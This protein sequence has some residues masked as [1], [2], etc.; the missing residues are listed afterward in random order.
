MKARRCVL[1]AVGM[2]GMEFQVA[3]AAH[4]GQAVEEWNEGSVVFERNE[5]LSLSDNG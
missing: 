1:W 2:I 3:G 4:G 5:G